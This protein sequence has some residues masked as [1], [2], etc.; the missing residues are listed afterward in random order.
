MEPSE[1]HKL[2]YDITGLT[3]KVQPESSFCVSTEKS[4]DEMAISYSVKVIEALTEKMKQF[5]SGSQNSK[6]SLAQLKEVYT[7]GAQAD[8]SVNDYDAGVWGMARVNLVIALKNGDNFAELFEPA[9][10]ATD[11]FRGEL[12]FTQDWLPSQKCFEQAVEDVKKYKLENFCFESAADLYLENYTKMEID[13][14]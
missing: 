13:I 5:N 9:L 2:E 10:K 1:L 3:P 11:D 6:I 7:R 4:K 12:D 8:D 14:L